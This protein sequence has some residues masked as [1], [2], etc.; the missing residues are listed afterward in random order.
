MDLYNR[1]VSKPRKN[2]NWMGFLDKEHTSG[3]H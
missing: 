1:Y 2:K 3:C